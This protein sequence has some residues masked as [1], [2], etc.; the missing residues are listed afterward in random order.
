VQV[1]DFNPGYD[2]LFWTVRVPSSAVREASDGSVTYSLQSFECPDWI[3]VANAFARGPNIPGDVSFDLRFKPR[4]RKH[5]YLH[6]PALGDPDRD[7]YSIVY[8][9]AT[10][11][12]TWSAE[13]AAGFRF[14]SYDRDDE[15]LRPGT[16]FGI[17]GRERNGIYT[18]AA[19]A[20][21]G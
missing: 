11:T 17:L 19:A 21:K 6:R 8:R 16:I 10:C 1:H 3:D 5:T 9:E 7:A 14:E 2:P 20:P 13:N 12:L 15:R 4:G 18:P